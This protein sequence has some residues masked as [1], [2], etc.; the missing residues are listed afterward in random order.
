MA[1]VIQPIQAPSGARNDVAFALYEKIGNP[2]HICAPMVDQSEL[3]FRMLTRRYGVDLCYTPMLHSVLFAKEEAYRKEFF[4]TIPEDRPL[5]VQFCAN[6]PAALL[7]AASLVADSCDAVDINLGC[8]QGIARRGHYGA[9]L[10]E[11]PELV[12][13]LVST[14]S[15]N[16]P[17]PVWAKIRILSSGLQK[18][19][20]FAQMLERA[21]AQLIAVHGRT[22]E[23]KGPTSGTADWD[24]IRI[25]REHVSVPVIANGS[26][27][28]YEDVT[29][30]L[31]RTGAVGVMAAEGL[32]ENPALFSGEDVPKLRLA[33]EYLDLAEEHGTPVGMVRA[34]LFR[35]YGTSALAAAPDLRDAL[36]AALTLPA[37]RSHWAE[38]CARF[39]EGLPRGP[40]PSQ[41][42]PAKARQEA[43]EALLD[44]GGLFGGLAGPD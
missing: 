28:S 37:L 18:T 3:A 20:Q 29:A 17:V 38:L 5:A 7:Q 44:G 11:E 41:A 31:G 19:I 9:F 24:A 23:Q 40:L 15:R 1:P 13:D 33:S 36:A 21:G 30:C 42:R 12:H 27:H 22:K 6:D 34:H 14:L 32:L 39:P 10:L 8:P 43:E 16:L 26:V 35:M 4:S 25:V 2:K